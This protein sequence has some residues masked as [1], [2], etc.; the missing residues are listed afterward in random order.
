VYTR[1][2]SLPPALV[3]ELKAQAEAAGIKWEDMALTDNTCPPHPPPRSIVE[4]KRERG[5][6]R[7]GGGL[8]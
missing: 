8:G 3:P 7:G 1:T 6:Q 4:V 5:G 2:R